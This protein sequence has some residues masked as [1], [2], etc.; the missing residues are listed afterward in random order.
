MEALEQF[1]AAYAN[2]L[3]KPEDLDTD[4][5]TGLPTNVVS[6]TSPWIEHTGLWKG[7]DGISRNHV[8]GQVLVEGTGAK[9][10]E[11]EALTEEDISK[12]SDEEL[13]ALVQQM[14]EEDN[15]EDSEEDLEDL[16]ALIQSLLE[17]DEEPV[18][19]DDGENDEVETE[20]EDSDSDPNYD[21]Q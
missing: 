19:Q 10:Q 3:Y 7:N 13:D 21:Y 15:L 11:D 14:I 16:D 5:M 18:A 2:Q 6:N 4:T 9:Q 20:A 12:L 1:R 17:D 8:P